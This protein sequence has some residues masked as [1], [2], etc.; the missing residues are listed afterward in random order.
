MTV[1]RRE[2]VEA[3]NSQFFRIRGWV[4][5][6]NSML[7]EMAKGTPYVYE[8][9]TEY[10][11]SRGIE[12]YFLDAGFQV[13]TYPLTQLTEGRVIPFDFIFHES[14]TYKIFGIQ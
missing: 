9:Q 5:A 13:L 14:K 3:L 6:R 8:R 1:H 11:T 10:W 4:T 12:E 7:V 2:F